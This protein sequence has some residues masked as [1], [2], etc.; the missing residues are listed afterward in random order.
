LK[1][2]RQLGYRTYDDHIDNSYDEIEDN[3]QRFKRVVDVVKQIKKLNLHQ[4]YCSMIDDMTYNRNRFI[5]SQDKLIK[6]QN[7]VEKIL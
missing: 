5:N 2:L 4:W 6:L 1:T 3:T 7:L